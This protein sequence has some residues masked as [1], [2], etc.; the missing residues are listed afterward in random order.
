MGAAPPTTS[1][2]RHLCERVMKAS[3]FQGQ[4]YLYRLVKRLAGPQPQ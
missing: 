2:W 1:T 4:D 3:F